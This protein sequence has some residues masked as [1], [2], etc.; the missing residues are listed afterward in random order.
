MR[1]INL[2]I[3]TK[4]NGRILKANLSW[5]QKNSNSSDAKNVLAL[6]LSFFFALKAK[7]QATQ[8]SSFNKLGNNHG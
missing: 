7:L 4:L 6:F 8:E 1:Q 5:T 2:A 3:T